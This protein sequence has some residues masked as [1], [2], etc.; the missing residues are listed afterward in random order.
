[1]KNQLLLLPFLCLLGAC[2]TSE[3]S[4]PSMTNDQAVSQILTNFGP[5]IAEPTYEKLLTE[6]TLL[7]STLEKLKIDPTETHLGQAQIQWYVTRSAWEQS[8]CM[9]FGPVATEGLDPAID[10]WPV[11]HLEIDSLLN[12]SF[13]I[14]ASSVDG[15]GEALK[16]FHPIEYYLFGIAKSRKATD[17]TVRQLEFLLALGQNLQAKT[18]AMW[19]GWNAAHGNY[20]DEMAQA[21]NG[22]KTYSTRQ[23]ALLEIAQAIIGIIG[24]VSDGK[25]HEPFVAKDSLLEESP[26]AQSS[27]SDFK[28][29]LHGARNTYNG[30]IYGQNTTSLQAWLKI[31]NTALDLKITQGFDQCIASLDAYSIPFGR[32]IFQVPGQIQATQQQLSQLKQTMENELIPLITLKVKN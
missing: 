3:N 14:S 16:G 23:E 28:D 30:A 2:A 7:V 9:L 13:A 24:E 12:S 17:L 5:K 8:E 18:R 31:H 21:G 19:E 15:L 25:I 1:M 20:S 32:A 6:A 26:F 29:N 10:T 4:E 11:S 22:S 27:W